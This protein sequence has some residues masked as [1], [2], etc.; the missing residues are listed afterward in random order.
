MVSVCEL[1]FLVRLMVKYQPAFVLIFDECETFFIRCARKDGFL[2]DS[3]PE[4]FRNRK[5]VVIAAVKKRPRNIEWASKE[6]RNDREVVFAA[7]CKGS[8]ISLKWAS[9]EIKKDKKFLLSLFPLELRGVVLKWTSEELKKDKEVVLAA[10]KSDASS[11]YYASP[12]LQKD[13]EVLITAMSED[14]LSVRYALNI[15]PFSRKYRELL[16]LR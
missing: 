9:E 12:E 8:C 11:I 1:F 4:I 16:S 3:V 10:V 15:H 13:R 5:D 7:M 14:P 6:L 2:L